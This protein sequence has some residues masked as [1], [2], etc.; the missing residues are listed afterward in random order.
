VAVTPLDLLAPKGKVE[1]SLFPGEA[2]TALAERLQEYIN[3][4]VGK[5]ASLSGAAHE[6]AVK[7][8]AYHRVFEQVFIRLANA[9]QSVSLADQGSKSYGARQA[10]YFKQ[11]ADGYADEFGMLV[12]GSLAPESRFPPTVQV[13]NRV[14]W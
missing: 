9:P 4:G 14:V 12:V 1:A 8:W 11:L 3:D 2:S 7:V 13:S 10:D 5:A 6:N